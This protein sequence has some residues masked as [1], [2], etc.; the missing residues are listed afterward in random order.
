MAPKWFDHW[1][2]WAGLTHITPAKGGGGN[3]SE[4]ALAAK[5]EETGNWID[6]T[7]S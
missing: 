7:Q 2:T 4:I 6:V 1:T 5:I 3:K